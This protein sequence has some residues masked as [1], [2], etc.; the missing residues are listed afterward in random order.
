MPR[1]AKPAGTVYLIHFDRPYRHAAHYLG[2]V[3]GG[4]SDVAAR[5][6][7]HRA[8][9]GARLMA[10]VTAAGIGWRL[11]R[12]WPGY[13]RRDERKLKCRKGAGRMCPVCL[14]ARRKNP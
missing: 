12:T 5:L 9:D 13:T 4:E 3:A 14:A 7:R 10:V 2:F 1:T 11:A 8:G 6:D